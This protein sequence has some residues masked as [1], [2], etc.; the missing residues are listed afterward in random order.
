M[1]GQPPISSS[2]SPERSALSRE[3]GEFLIELSI[4]LHK[5]SM[6]PQGHPS[7]QPAAAGVLRRLVQ[8]LRE[9]GTLS[10]GVARHQLIIEGVAT[11]SKHPVLSELAGRLHRHHLGAVSFARGIEGG[12]LEEG[13]R[14]LSAEPGRGVEAIGLQ[15]RDLVPQWDHV[16]L[17][18]M[19]YDRLELLDED[20]QPVGTKAERA[21]SAQL[22]I[23]LARAALAGGVA[24]D[25]AASELKAAVVAEAINAHEQGAAYDQVIVGYLLQIAEELKSAGGREAMELRKRTSRMIAELRPETLKRLVDMGGDL[26]QRHKF[27]LDAT[28]GMA[29]DAVI[30]IVRAAASSSNQTISHSLVR[31]LSKMAAHAEQG[32]AEARPLADAALRDQVEQLM[33]GWQLQDPNPGAYGKA[34]QEMSRAAPVFAVAA[35]AAFA[36]EDERLVEMAIEIDVSGPA[37]W[38]AVDRMVSSD[39]FPRLLELLEGAPAG[40]GAARAI[41]H[42]IFNIEAVARL[43][44]EPQPN[45]ALVDRLVQVVGA[46]A[47]APLLDALATA[48]VRAVRRALLDR[49]GKM[50]EAIVPELLPRLNDQRWYVVRNLLALLDDLSALPAGF[51]PASFRTHADA[52]VR[53]QALK[54]ELKHPV[55]REQAL[56]AA[57]A[58]RDPQTLHLAL[59]ATQSDCPLSTVPL[60]L[61]HARNDSL[62]SEDRVLAIRSLGRSGAPEALLVLVDLTDGGRTLLG[63]AKL[64]PKS[65]EFLA[66][67]QALA[68]GWGTDDRAT[69]V[70]ARA[71]QSRDADVRAATDPGLGTA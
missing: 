37:V 30:E 4:A 31:M 13:L 53:R 5:H 56:L 23:G 48:D 45:F 69:A 49:L 71:A 59:M 34:L 64:P 46:S 43:L 47:A 15:P 24:D 61:Q 10:L 62:P 25:D 50:G 2:P 67:L 68:A 52:R 55:E 38:G 60:L 70:L 17:H 63:R 57:L 3:L 32:S 54:L 66:A 19:T 20:G 40:G 16:K 7:L 11:D 6:Y 12:E 18:P 22:W 39:Q 44:A 33:S 26:N 36:P 21:K 1:T 65:P 29:V 14:L 41:R 9:R 35:E 27:V 42:R 58:D 51:S 8:L 28:H